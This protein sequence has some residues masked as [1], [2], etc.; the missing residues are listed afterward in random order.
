[1]AISQV[2][3]DT[4]IILHSHVLP[5]LKDSSFSTLHPSY[6]YACIY[7]LPVS[8]SVPPELLILPRSN[9]CEISLDGNAT[10]A[11]LLDIEN[12]LRLPWANILQ[13]TALFYIKFYTAKSPL[14]I[15]K[16][17]KCL[18][19]AICSMFLLLMKSVTWIFHDCC[20]LPLLLLPCG[21]RSFFEFCLKFI[22]LLAFCF[23]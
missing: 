12:Q 20:G 17:Q 4:C 8:C 2:R 10:S 21:V 19:S 11:D 23:L 9:M 6:H 1:M 14:F 18:S 7:R 22:V 16:R 3:L 13:E 5:L 15:P